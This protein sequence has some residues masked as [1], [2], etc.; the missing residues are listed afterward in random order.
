MWTLNQES[1]IKECD[2][3]KKDYDLKKGPAIESL[4]RFKWGKNICEKY[5]HSS[6]ASVMQQYIDIYN[7]Y[8]NKYIQ[9]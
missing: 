8:L 1:K 3:L 5:N 2:K 7:L 6:F 4:N 9:S